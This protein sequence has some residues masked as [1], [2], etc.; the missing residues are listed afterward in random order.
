VELDSVQIRILGCL[1]EKQRTT[2]DGYPLSLNALRNACNQATNREPVVAYDEASVRA[3]LGELGRMRLIRSAHGHGGRAL[4]YRHLLDDALGLPPE[5]LALLAVL[6]LRGAQTPGELRQRVER[7][8][9][10]ADP[11]ALHAALEGLV[12]RGHVVRLQRRPGQK[13][14]RYEQRLG[15]AEESAGSAPGAQDAAPSAPGEASAD[16]RIARLE[17]EIDRLR[18]RVEALEA[19]G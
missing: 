5:Q 17:R 15:G 8:H 11:T 1:I 9:R 7:L 6:M 18:S 12:E 19:G 4:K 14:E 13:E 10:F 3:A 16:E 2:P